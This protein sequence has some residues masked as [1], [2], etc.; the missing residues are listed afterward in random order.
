MTPL[1]KNIYGSEGGSEALDVLMK[2]MYDPKHRLAAR[3]HT[4]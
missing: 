4:C 3:K 1:L 2:Y